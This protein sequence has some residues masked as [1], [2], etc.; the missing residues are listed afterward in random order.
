M[1][2]S[3]ADSR[4][5]PHPPEPLGPADVV[6][7]LAG[8]IVHR[9]FEVGLTLDSVRSSA[10]DGPSG[11]QVVAAADEVDRLIS[12]IRDHVFAEHGQGTHGWPARKSRP[13]DQ[14]RPAQAAN[15]VALLQ[16]HLARTA[17]ALQAGA[18][19]YAALLE[20]KADLSRQPQQMDYPAEIKRWRAFARSGRA[21]GQ[22]LGT[23]AVIRRGP[24]RGT[25]S[26]GACWVPAGLRHLA[27]RRMTPC[28]V[29]RP[30]RLL[31][32]KPR[33]TRDANGV[34]K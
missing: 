4:N 27:P 20:H 28:L 16:E 10:G 14:Y 18:A 24:R 8:Y 22:T 23:A 7:D 30:A 9:L 15:R 2:M 21:H 32:T 11:D 34:I 29:S 5:L 3:D 12:K 17:R 25:G 26:T 13:D 31:R 19:D 33:K 1:L 6:S